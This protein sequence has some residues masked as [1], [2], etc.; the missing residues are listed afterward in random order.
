MWKQQDSAVT[1]AKNECADNIKYLYALE[2]YCEPL[3]KYDPTIIPDYIPSLL[4]A[5]RM[6]F[7]TSRYYNTTENVTAILVKVS[8]QMINVCRKYLNCNKT[9]TVWTQPKQVVLDKIKVI[10]WK[11]LL[12]F[13]L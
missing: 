8:N 10:D 13:D 7:T 1:D 5:I 6:V 9:K 11:F 2:K 4:Y 3:Y 12:A